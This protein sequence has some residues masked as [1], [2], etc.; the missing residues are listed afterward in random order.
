[1]LN[2]PLPSQ[3]V[4]RKVLAVSLVNGWSITIVAGLSLL[5]TLALGDGLGIVVSLLV[6]G[7]GV[8]ELRGRHW[9]KGGDTGGGRWLL[10]AQ[11]GL[12][13]VIYC[14]CLWQLRHVDPPGALSSLPAEQ[15]K[16]FESIGYTKAALEKSVT[17]AMV[18]IYAG[19]M[20]ASLL[21]QGGLYYFYRRSLAKIDQALVPPPIPTE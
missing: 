19:V 4:I 21:H 12:M 7:A 9:L 15:L 11:L 18:A 20:L 2:P 3:S 17:V 6:T 16:I 10:A 5:V 13:A 1:M 8:V 14:Y